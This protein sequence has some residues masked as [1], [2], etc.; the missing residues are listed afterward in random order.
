MK[1]GD[2]RALEI[3][4][5][6]APNVEMSGLRL[7]PSVLQFGNELAFSFEL[8]NT[9]DEAQNLM[10]DYVMHFVKANGSTAPKV[11]KLKK[12]KLMSGESA[13]VS[14]KMA[15]RPI[16]TRKYYAG[17]QRLEIQVNGRILD[18]ADFELVMDRRR[19]NLLI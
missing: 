6:G 10:I 7:S 16:S 9:G 4:G 18:G 3:L 12:M 11:F 14:K 13:T 5:Y 1:R 8:R 19:L 15:I 2:R 17:R